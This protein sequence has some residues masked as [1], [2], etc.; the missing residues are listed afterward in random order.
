[1]KFIFTCFIAWA[2]II[3]TPQEV[4]SQTATQTAD[5]SQSIQLKVKGL[6]CSMDLKTIATNVEKLKGVSACKPGKV[7]AVSKFE[8]IFNPLL[9]TEKQIIEAIENTAGCEDEND[10]PYKVKK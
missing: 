2:M 7:G 9:V 10:R 6:T 8:V 5:S 3:V 4:Y 1:M